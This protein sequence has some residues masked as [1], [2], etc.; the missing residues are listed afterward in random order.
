M[1]ILW[2]NSL[3]FGVVGYG[4]VC[5]MWLPVRIAQGYSFKR[6]FAIFS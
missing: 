4:G 3:V 5:Q 6:Y 2:G 1:A